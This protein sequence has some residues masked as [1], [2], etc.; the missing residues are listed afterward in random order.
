MESK[1]A[2]VVKERE[3]SISTNL[4]S[5]YIEA[6]TSENTR[7]AYR[8]DIRHFQAWGGFL[9]A[10]VPILIDYLHAHAKTLNPRTLHRRLVAIRNWHVYSKYPD[11]TSDPIVRKT[12]SGIHH[13]HGKPKNKAPALSVE[14][15]KK[16]VS[17]LKTK[18]SD[19]SL[20]DSALIQIGFFG[21]FRRSELVAIKYEDISF[22]EKG[23]EIMVPKSKADQNGN[24]GACAIPYGD[25]EVCAVS[26]LKEWLEKSGIKSGYI[27]PSPRPTKE[28]QHVM[29]FTINHV[30]KA[31]AHECGILNSIR[32]SGHSLRRGLA[33]AASLNGATVASIMRQGRWSH[34]A[35]VLEYIEEGERF[36]ENA[37]STILFKQKR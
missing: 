21:A 23:V 18:K 7:R 25:S 6:A 26:A 36:R 29:V 33:T 15:L 2:V 27:F 13:V 37:V 16:I 30:L 22:V 3:S 4:N 5:L 12:V 11:P 24:G 20:R 8:S 28:F 32:Y 19:R 17:L 35:T 9:P 10:N 34:H 14:N 1:M 31:Y